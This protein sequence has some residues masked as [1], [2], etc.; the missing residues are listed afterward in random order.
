MAQI[1]EDGA[2]LR[3]ETNRLRAAVRTEGYVSGVMAQSFEDKQTGARDPGFGLMIVDFLLEPGAESDDTPDELRYHVGDAY[4]GNI[5]KRYV[6]LP[7]ICTRAK[8]LPFEIIRGPDFVAVRQWF[9]WTTARPPYRPGSRWDQWLVFPDGVRWFLAYDRVTSANDV[10]CLAL[11]T[12][13]PGHIKHDVGDTFDQLY[14]SYYGELPATA[15]YD[16]FSPDD[17]YLYSREEAGVPERF[18]R[19]CRLTDGPW[20]LGMCLDS[21]AAYESWCHQRGYVCMI[22]EIGGRAVR[23]G[24]SFGAVHLIGYFDDLTEAKHTFDEHKGAT[25]LRVRAGEWRLVS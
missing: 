9:T 3:I 8:K 2:V 5:Q 16:D 25:A 13:M 1:E 18:I 14:L 19:G 20:L 22:H 6:E 17:R 12:D 23:A 24:R 11:R 4:H 21:A 15:F 10:E 7:Q